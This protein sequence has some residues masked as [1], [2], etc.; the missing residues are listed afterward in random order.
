MTPD[1]VSGDQ[2]LYVKQYRSEI[3][4]ALG[5]VDDIDINTASTAYEINVIWSVAK[6]LKES[7][8]TIYLWIVPLFSMMVYSEEENF[9]KSFAY[10]VGLEEPVIPLPEDFP[11]EEEYEIEKANYDQLRVEFA[12]I[13]MKP[14][15]QT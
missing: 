15:V 6:Q 1:A 2:N 9:K 3:R 12:K 7:E 13:E 4:L 11:T 5:G 8:G 10:A 14:Y